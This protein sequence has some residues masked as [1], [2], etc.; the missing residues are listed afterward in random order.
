MVRIR[1]SDL[2]DAVKMFLA[3]AQQGETIVVEDDNGRLQCGVTPYIQA[4][5]DEKRAALD[6]L[7][8]LQQK[9]AQSMAQLGVTET[10]ID[11]ELQN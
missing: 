2:D 1:L 8:R 5:A 9:S 3:R 11:R 6:A 7:G 4:T 10:D